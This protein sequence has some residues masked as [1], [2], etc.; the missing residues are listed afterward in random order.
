[1][2]NATEEFG[3]APRDV[4]NGVLDL[5]S[6]RDRH[7]PARDSPNCSELRTLRRTILVSRA[8][9]DFSFSHRVVVYPVPCLLNDSWAID[10]KSIRI[11]REMVESM[12]LE[13]DQ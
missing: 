9:N 13:E 4:C 8:L 5:P 1:V 3:F 10:F 7:A 6:T 2:N 12:R 11:A